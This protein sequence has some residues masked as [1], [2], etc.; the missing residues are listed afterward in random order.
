LTGQKT[1]LIVEDEV[2]T[3]EMLEE[4]VRLS[5]FR[6][7][8]S[9]GGASSIKVIVH[10]QPDAML[11]DLGMPDVSG[12]EVLRFVLRDP[13]LLHIPVIILSAKNS[14][15]DIKM[16]LDSGAA[17]YLIKPVSFMELRKTIDQVTKT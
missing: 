11:L 9:H 4:M 16:G 12:L 10:E 5:G 15:V 1:V 14:P 2:E 7:I 17:A 13:Q 8:K 3:A 6:A